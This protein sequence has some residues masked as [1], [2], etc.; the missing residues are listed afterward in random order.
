MFKLANEKALIDAIISLLQ[1]NDVVIDMFKAYHLPISN[2]RKVPIEFSDINVSAKT[3]DGKILLNR[4][5]LSD[6]NF[7][8]DV[9][10]I[11]HELTHW[12]QQV[13]GTPTKDDHKDYLDM[14]DEIEAFRN[15]YRFLKNHA[16]AEEADAY[17]ND[18]LDFHELAGGKRKSKYKEL[19]EG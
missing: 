18:L 16:R 7:E 2:I 6:G 10:Y 13:Y 1:Y 15:Q 8:D 4:E 5:L 14:K 3:R 17:V 11:I 12:L 19:T 9:H